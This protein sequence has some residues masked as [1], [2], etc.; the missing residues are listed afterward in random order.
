[1]E[2]YKW[3]TISQ[4]PFHQRKFHVLKTFTSP[5][6]IYQN[7]LEHGLPGLCICTCIWLE[8]GGCS[9]GEKYK[10]AGVVK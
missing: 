4:W 1:M 8:E 9:E 10:Y 3:G 6:R 5:N 2:Q 7:L